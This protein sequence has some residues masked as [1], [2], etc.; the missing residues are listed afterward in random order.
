MHFT[1]CDLGRKEKN[2]QTAQERRKQWHGQATVAATAAGDKRGASL[3]TTE[4]VK[5]H[6]RAQ[7]STAQQ[8]TAQHSTARHGTQNHTA[9]GTA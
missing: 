5:Q 1:K 7:H 2:V 4:R 8:K 9:H 6:N 3:N